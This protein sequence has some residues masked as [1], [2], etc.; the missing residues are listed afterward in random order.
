MKEQCLIKGSGRSKWELVL[1]VVVGTKFSI[2]ILTAK[3]NRETY[4]LYK[5]HIISFIREP[6]RWCSAFPVVQ[7]CELQS[8]QP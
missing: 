3:G 6:F 5:F 8:V 7:S 4:W 1:K 2:K